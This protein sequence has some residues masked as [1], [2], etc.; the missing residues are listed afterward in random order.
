MINPYPLAASISLVSISP[1]IPGV[2]NVSTNGPAGWVSSFYLFML[3]ISG[4]LA[5]A[6]MIY[7]GFRYATSAGNASKQNEGR[8]FIWSALIG[9]LLLAAAYL[10]LKTINPNLV[11]LQNP[12][13]T[14]HP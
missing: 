7:G 6:A 11:I 14:S 2:T 1:N 9:L 13:L 5:F 3:L 10:L 4:I 12:T 8:A